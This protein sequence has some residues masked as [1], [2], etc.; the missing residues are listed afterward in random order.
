MGNRMLTLVNMVSLVNNGDNQKRHFFCDLPI[1]RT[2]LDNV[3]LKV[4]VIFAAYYM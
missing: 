4:R 1:D 3:V 2:P